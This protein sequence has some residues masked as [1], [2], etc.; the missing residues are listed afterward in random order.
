MPV[1]EWGSG[2]SGLHGDP[3]QLDQLLGMWISALLLPA[4]LQLRL[5]DMDLTQVLLDFRQH[6][7]EKLS[8]SNS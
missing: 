6:S 1:K 2:G 5:M 4:L 8:I 7:M 3:S